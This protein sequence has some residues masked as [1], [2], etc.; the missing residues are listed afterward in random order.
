VAVAL[1]VYQW[2]SRAT[3]RVRLADGRLRVA[4]ACAVALLYGGFVWFFG[5]L[6][7]ANYRAL[8]TQTLDLGLYDN[9]LWHTAHGDPLGTS[10]LPGGHHG[11]AHFDPILIAFAPLY[12][13]RPAAD[14]LLML[15]VAWVGS[16]VV[17]VYLFA[18][19]KLGSPLAG[20]AFAA[21]Y[22]AHPAVHGATLYEFHSLALASPLLV[23]LVYFL[24]RGA[25]RRYWLVL[26]LAL[27]CRE[28]LALLLCFVGAYA[29][30]RGPGSLRVG[31]ITVLVSLVYFT[32]VKRFFMDSPDLLNSGPS[33][34]G[35]GYYY[36]ELIPNGNGVAGLALSLITNPAFVLKNALTEPK[37]VFVAVLLLPLGLLP[38]AARPGRVLL[39]YGLAFCMLATKPAVYSISF[40][41]S[42]VLLPL[43]FPAAAMALDEV[44]RWRLV[45]RQS[46]DP[47]RLRR[48]LL[49][50]ALVASAL[51]SWKLGA[52][53]PGHPFRA[54][55]TEVKRTLDDA[56]RSRFEWLRAAARS[57]PADASVAATTRLGPFVSNRREAYD[58]SRGNG[59]YLLVDT[60]DLKSGEAES[61]DRMVSQGSLVVLDEHGSLALYRRSP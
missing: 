24:E 42:C 34:Y 47:A 5:H 10:Y 51:V 1:S 59:R 31:W 53:D 11:S 15:Q 54:G 41:Y 12:L 4:G 17:P 20:V 60:R 49:A 26:G 16:T 58:Y 25:L 44:G 61:L 14:S 45:A 52:L 30:L 2:P 18:R 33:S 28:D 3:S 55:F 50:F 8:D 21:M 56:D 40:Q 13:L 29:A 57:I 37:V 22:A 7:I 46:L 6:A 27:F 35:Y 9:L 48:A 23:W 36:A 39:V 32:I 38:L 43:A 19:H